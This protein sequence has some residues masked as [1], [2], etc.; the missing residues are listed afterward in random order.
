MSVRLYGGVRLLGDGPSISNIQKLDHGALPM[1]MAMAKEGLQV[2][3]DHF[4]KMEDKLTNLMEQTTEDVRSMTGYYVNLDSGDQVADLLFKKLGL[5]Q[6]RSKMTKSGKR[7]SVIDEVLTAIQHD[8]PVVSKVQDYKEYSKLKGTYVKPIIRL[9]V[10]TAHGVWKLF[11]NLTT[12]RVPSGRLACKEPNLL[13][14]PT[15][16]ELGRDIRRGFIADAGWKILSVDESQIEVRL[17]AH[18]SLDE[19]LLNVYR[20]EEDIY[21]DFAITAF[22]LTDDRY[23]NDEGKWMYP[24]VHKMDHRYP[25][26][27]CILASIYDV[28]PAGLLEHMPVICG[29]C[30]LEA[31]RHNCRKF[32]SL[33]TEEKCGQLIAAFYN[34][35]PGIMEDRKRHHA[36]A[37]KHGYVWDMW[38]RILHVA[39]V[40]SVHPWIVSGALREV[41]NFPYQSGAQGTIKLVMASA[42]DLWK[43]MKLQEVVRPLLQCHD[44]LLYACR[45]D[46]AED[47]GETVKNE[48]ENCAPLAVPIKAEKA[49]AQTWG[50]IAK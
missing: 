18:Y 42:H 33:W 16:T 23:C 10:C 22:S 3:L 19:G 6:A 30:G 32:R 46:V 4:H 14:M 27:T 50:D 36:R 26:K 34:K 43:L 5:K 8:H 47:W 28:S 9:S 17:A 45:D 13:A 2:D 29:G 21:S 12:T 41:G 1:I 39:G 20:H 15:R 40:R 31:R 11:P 38:G 37:K 44:E 49:M 7:E 48:F 25:A 35:Y 24:S